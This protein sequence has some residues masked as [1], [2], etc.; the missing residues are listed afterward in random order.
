MYGLSITQRILDGYCA[1]VLGFLVIPLLILVPLAF[2][3]GDVVSFPPVGWSRAPL[4]KVLTDA[5]WLATVGQSLAVATS[6]FMQT[7]KF[8]RLRPVFAA[9]SRADGSI[10][11]R[12]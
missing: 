6:G 9:P 7:S 12:M 1:L 2:V 11:S 4:H 8:F 5:N 3:A 10:T